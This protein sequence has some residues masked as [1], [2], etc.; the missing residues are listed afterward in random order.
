MPATRLIRKLAGAENIGQN[1]SS[2][3]DPA[4]E[5]DDTTGDDTTG[6]D[7]PPTPPAVSS[8]AQDLVELGY[9]LD[10]LRQAARSFATELAEGIEGND[11]DRLAGL[12]LSD[13]ELRPI[14]TDGG[15]RILSGMILAQSRKK[16]ADITEAAARKTTGHSW[17]PG[18]LHATSTDS[19]IW[20]K[21]A[22]L[23]IGSVLGLEVGVA[24]IL[25]EIEQ[26]VYVDEKWRILRIK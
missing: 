10:T 12:V 13:A 25:L 4:A 18:S 22:P 1:G 15:F 26:L 7:S 21:R 24:P 3:P 11:A 2:R 19:K 9:D 5:D 8:N 16:L 20:A 17:T 23:M 14:A 6:D